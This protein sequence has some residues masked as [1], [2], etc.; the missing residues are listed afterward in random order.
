MKT[1]CMLS[2]M[3]PLF[4]DR[5]YWKEAVSL[6]KFGYH[7]I[8]IGFDKERKDIISDEGIRI[9]A[10]KKRVFSRHILIHK[11][12]KT[13]L[14]D[15]PHKQM[16]KKIIEVQADAY[17]IHDLKVNKL[18]RKIRKLPW[19]PKIIYDVHEDYG[20]M[21]RYYHRKKGL[22]KWFTF[23]YA[24]I[25]DRNEKRRTKTYDYYLHVTKE[26]QEKFAY[27][28]PGV[29]SALILNYSNLKPLNDQYAIEKKYD[30]LYS[31]LISYNRGALEII[32]AAN[33]LNRTYSDVRILFLGEFE[34]SEFEKLFKKSISESN[35]EDT[36]IYH[37]YVIQNKV[38]TYY[39]QSK[40]GVCTLHPIKKFHNSI[41]IKIFEYM[42]FGMPVIASN[43]AYMEFY[44]QET[45]AGI[46]V[47]PLSP[48]EIADAVIYLLCNKDE[49]IRMQKNG[50][51][52]IET[53]YHWSM[54]EK[55]LISIYNQLL[56]I[57]PETISTKHSE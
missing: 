18:G 31:G 21:L 45:G 36:V 48:E 37:P 49:Y 42:S 5:I 13:L 20:D 34:S 8:H 24:M 10:I 14:F 17:H 46:L 30:I 40:I 32:K 38:S 44:I 29:K 27:V 52:A 12:I 55:K 3:H 28:N 53:K 7:V 9:I 57:E 2:D 54:E 19:K 47:D 39:C 22:L 43:F 25:I 26:I 33:I 16:M 56:Q 50:L 23:L 6:K 35:L 15:D 4:D 51:H 41:P 11:F 1:I